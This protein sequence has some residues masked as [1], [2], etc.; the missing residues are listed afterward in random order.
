MEDGRWKAEGGRQR[1]D[2]RGQRAEERRWKMED[3]RQ[4]IEE[5]RQRAEERR[6]RAEDRIPRY[7]SGGFN[8]VN[9]QKQG[10]R[11]RV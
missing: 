1:T 9:S 5:R 3:G 7:Y 8:F 11:V 6:W 4:E 2:D 10:P